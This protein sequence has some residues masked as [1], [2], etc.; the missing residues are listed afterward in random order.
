MLERLAEC[1]CRHRTDDN[2]PILLLGTDCSRGSSASPEGHWFLTELIK[3]E[4]FDENEIERLE[5]IYD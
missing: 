2:K 1:I 3:K 5:N 4:Y